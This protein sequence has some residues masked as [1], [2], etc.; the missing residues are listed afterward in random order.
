[1]K[2]LEE[3]WIWVIPRV[4]FRAIMK[5]VMLIRG[6]HMVGSLHPTHTIPIRP[7]CHGSSLS[8]P[9]FPSDAIPMQASGLPPLCWNYG[10]TI[11]LIDAYRLKWYSLNCKNLRPCIGRRSPTAWPAPPPTSLPSRPS[12]TNRDHLLQR[13]PER[14]EGD[15]RE[16]MKGGRGILVIFK[17]QGPT[18]DEKLRNRSESCFDSQKGPNCNYLTNL[19]P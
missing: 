17:N 15:E 8:S 3:I 1:M 9:R 2:L 11:A 5:I 6:H 10:E 19:N 14:G 4:S 12:A 18:F 13:W 16:T 7:Y